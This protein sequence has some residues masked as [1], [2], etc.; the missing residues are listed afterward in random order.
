[1]FV[2]YRHNKA[3]RFSE[4]FQNS[5]F[6]FSKSLISWDNNLK[7]VAKEQLFSISASATYI[8]AVWT[9]HGVPP[10]SI[11]VSCRLTDNM[12][13][14]IHLMGQT[15]W[16]SWS[17]ECLRVGWHWLQTCLAKRQMLTGVHFLQ[18]LWDNGTDD[19]AANILRLLCV[20]FYSWWFFG[21]FGA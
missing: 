5:K 2:P 3:G 4:A 18:G 20:S 15:R 16:T 1:M 9:V 8:Q 21:F 7:K 10:E 11:I 17:A 14:G 6:F 13:H 19:N 12:A